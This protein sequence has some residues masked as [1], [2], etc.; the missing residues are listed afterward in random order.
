[1]VLGILLGFGVWGLGFFVQLFLK[2]LHLGPDYCPAVSLLG[3]A[4]VKILMML[5]R[6]EKLCQRHD[7]RD[8]R[9][10]NCFCA[11]A[12]DFSAAVFCAGLL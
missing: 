2:F 9:A 12:F 10:V 11:S 6:F 8:N 1:L 3:M 4:A 7:L 5:L